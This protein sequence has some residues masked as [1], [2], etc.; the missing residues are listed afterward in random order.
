MSTQYEIGLTTPQRAGVEPELFQS[1][2]IENISAALL[3]TP[4]PP[5]L[6]RAPTGSGKTLV[7]GQVLERVCAEVPTLWLWF[8]PFVTLVAQTEDALAANAPGL[9]PVLLARGR[10]Q[11]ARAGMVLLSTAQ[12]VARAWIARQGMP[13]ARM[14]MSAAWQPL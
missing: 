2:L 11:E 3:R 5:C 1:A 10:N 8:V 14:T 4:A 7:L 9:S 13:R 6:L 12:A